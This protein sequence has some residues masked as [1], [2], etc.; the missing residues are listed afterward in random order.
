LGGI[1]LRKKLRDNLGTAALALVLSIIVWVNATYQNDRPYEDFYSDPIPVQVLNAPAGLV[2]TN[3]PTETVR[4]RIKA[5][6]STWNA[7]SSNNFVATAD[8]ADL[9]EGMHTVPINVT[10]S[11][12]TVTIVS[13]HPQMSYVRLEP[14][15][16]ATREVSVELEERDDVPMGYRIYDPEIEPGAVTIEGALSA[17]ERVA[18]VVAPVSLSGQRTTL[19]REVEL[20]VLDEDGRPVDNV[21]LSPQRVSVRVPIERREN[22]REVAVRARTQGQPARGY[23]VS[24]VNVIPS[25]VTIVGPPSVIDAMGSLI[26]VTEDIDVT[27]ATRMVA[28]RVELSLPEGVSVLG[29]NENQPFTVLVTVGIDA[30]TGGST[31]ELPIQTRRLQDGLS[32]QLSV[33]RIDV[34]LT[35]PSVVLDELEVDLLN[36]YVDLSGLGVGTHQV[37]PEVE[38]LSDQDSTLRD[39]VVKD[40]LP[41]YIEVTI[42]PGPTPTPEASARGASVSQGDGR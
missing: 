11:D 27:G 32:A 9:E 33:P 25:T 5:F 16:Q 26:D 7:L 41:K 6:S 36:A 39:L 29:A 10:S 18:Q 12:P 4:I 34:I 1:L 35:G 17:V 30:V 28:E 31:V 23:F 42:S 2:A 22:Y 15:Q 38:F 3:D 37:R 20:V 8:W 13:V 24:G 14:L 21:W 19:E 40:I